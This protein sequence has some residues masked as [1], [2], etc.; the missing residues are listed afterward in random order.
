MLVRHSS[1]ASLAAI[2]AIASAR[3]V[4]DAADASFLLLLQR[5]YVDSFFVPCFHV[6]YLSFSRQ[7]A[8]TLV[9]GR[10]NFLRISLPQ[11]KA[12][13]TRLQWLA[14]WTGHSSNASQTWTCGRP[15]CGFFLIHSFVSAF[16]FTIFVA[17]LDPTHLDSADDV[18]FDGTDNGDH[19]H[20]TD[21]RD[22]GSSYESV[23]GPDVN[24]QYAGLII[25]RIFLLFFIR[26]SLFQSAKHLS[27]Y[28]FDCHFFIH[29][30]IAC[31]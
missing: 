17:V 31:L 10:Y 9:V 12:Y 25:L 29:A 30:S 11:T 28:F 7:M 5:P 3:S 16:P 6:R 19:Q 15:K 13:D 22:S 24:I 2:S 8:R 26:P 18:Y 27:T 14:A 21:A 23:F 1:A 20:S 4:A